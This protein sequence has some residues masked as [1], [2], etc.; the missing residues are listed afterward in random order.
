MGTNRRRQRKQNRPLGVYRL[1][2]RNLGRNW[3]ACLLS[4]L[5]FIPYIFIDI[6]Y[7]FT[8]LSG[9]ITLF[10]GLIFIQS[11]RAIIKL[12]QLRK[13]LLINP[14]SVIEKQITD[15]PNIKTL[16]WLP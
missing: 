16:F 14:H 6:Q 13:K 1:L 4:G 7:G 5:I 12:R 2:N 9:F 10:M 11:I 15:A 3:T 8:I